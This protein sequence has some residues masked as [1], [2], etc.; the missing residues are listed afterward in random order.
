MISTKS[1]QQVVFGFFAIAILAIMYGVAQ[2][3]TSPR[4]TITRIEL[5]FKRDIRDVDSFRGV[6]LWSTAPTFTG[7]GCARL[8]GV[9]GPRPAQR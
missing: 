3:Q 2:A 8:P 1:G 7:A 9:A 5:S 6:G 4:A